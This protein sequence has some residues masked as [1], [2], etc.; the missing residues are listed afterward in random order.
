[1]YLSGM[2]IV[3][4]ADHRLMYLFYVHFAHVSVRIGYCLSVRASVHLLFLTMSISIHVSI[5][6]YFHHVSVRIGYCPSGSSDVKQVKL[7]CVT[8]V[9]HEIVDKICDILKRHSARNDTKT[10]YRRKWT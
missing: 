2:D 9:A 10:E 6:V 7:S 8:L 3:L 5:H 4:L 1:M